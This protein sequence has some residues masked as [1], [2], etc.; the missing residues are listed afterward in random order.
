MGSI[1]FIA[2]GLAGDITNGFYNRYSDNQ[3][4]LLDFHKYDYKEAY[5]LE[6]CFLNEDQKYSDFKDECFSPATQNDGG[7]II[8]W[9]DSHSAALSYGLRKSL[10]DLTQLTTG[11]CTLIIGHNPISKPN[12]TDINN[13]ILGKIEQLKPRLL[14]LHANWSD[15]L[16]KIKV[17]LKEGLL[18]TISYIRS[19]SLKTRIIIG[20]VPQWRPSLP[21]LLVK[22]NIELRE[23][24]YVYS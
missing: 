23:M 3:K 21:A 4:V 8:L 15:P 11:G 14:I 12:C 17:G 18:S 2:V 16:N 22:S 1:I 19:V 5:R 13:Y 7:S 10:R 24:A 20:G 6:S 9:G